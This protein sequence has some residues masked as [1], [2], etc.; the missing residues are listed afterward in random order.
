MLTTDPRV[1]KLTF[2]G[3]TAVGK[4]IAAKCMATV[5][6]V[7]LELGETRRSS[8]SRTRTSSAP[9]RSA[10]VSKFRNAGQT[11]VCANRLLIQDE[12]YDEFAAR[13][14]ERVERLEI[15]PLINEAAIRKVESHVAD[16]LDHGARLLKG[17]VRHRSPGN[18]YAPTLLSEVAAGHAAVS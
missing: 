15:G 14:C 11:C 18:F 16:A 13:L 3:S 1:R 10:I 2:T 9:W 17:G 8:C 4:S 7:S 6:R 5:K 12:V